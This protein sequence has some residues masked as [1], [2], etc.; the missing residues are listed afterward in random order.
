MAFVFGSP[1][2]PPEVLRSILERRIDLIG[3]RLAFWTTLVVLGLLFEYGA[4]IAGHIPNGW[5]P[6][7]PRAFKWIGIWKFTGMLLI[8]SGVSGELFVGVLA[9]AY[10]TNLRDFNTSINAAQQRDIAQSNA[11]AA[12]ANATSEKLRNENLTLQKEILEL[13]EKLADRGISRSE[14][15]KMLAVLKPYPGERVWITSYSVDAGEPYRYALKIAGVFFDAK[16]SLMP[17]HNE[18]PSEA[19]SGVR[20]ITS[21]RDS[22]KNVK[23]F[24]KLACIVAKAL[25]VGGVKPAPIPERR[26]HHV[27]E[28]VIEIRV[29]PK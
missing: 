22:L 29:G 12:Q 28:N 11:V 21:P 20:I 7:N 19:F 1:L 26:E 6:K 5:K 4:E 17:V 3:N 24:K 15:S 23:D 13:R 25:D 2:P 9:S 27:G 10:E 8:T 14:R 18:Q 16:W